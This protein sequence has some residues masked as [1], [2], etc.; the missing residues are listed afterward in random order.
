MNIKTAKMYDDA[1]EASERL[2]A[3]LSSLILAAH[4]IRVP[5]AEAYASDVGRMAVWADKIEA[6]AQVIEAETLYIKEG[7]R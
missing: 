4:G 2:T 6:L 3:S 5:P 7:Q 1:A